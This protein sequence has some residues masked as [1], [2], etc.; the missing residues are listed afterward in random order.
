MCVVR[1][2]SSN[3]ISMYGFSLVSYHDLIKASQ[4]ETYFFSKF[5][6]ISICIIYILFFNQTHIF[7]FVIYNFFLYFYSYEIFFSISSSNRDG[8]FEQDTI[9]RHEY[10]GFK[11]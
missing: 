6:V 3:D 4:T 9:T 11:L 5:Y 1:E 7:V 10:Y 2:S 8:N